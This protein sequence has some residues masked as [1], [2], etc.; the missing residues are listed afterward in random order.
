MTQVTA[1]TEKFLSSLKRSREDDAP[2]VSLSHV[3]TLARAT[4]LSD[5]ARF[6]QIPTNYCFL[7][8]TDRE[9]H[10]FTH[11]LVQISDFKPTPSNLHLPIESRVH[12]IG[13]TVKTV[14]YTHEDY[15]SLAVLSSILT[16]K[17]LHREVR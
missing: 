17:Y 3:R 4:H 10:M 14:P 7:H 5:R 16:D 11:F 12:Y 8:Q 9:P 1:E 15:A 2:F 6:V 13:T